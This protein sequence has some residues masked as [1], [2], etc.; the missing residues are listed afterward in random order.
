MMR[1]LPMCGLLLLLNISVG[2]QW[3]QEPLPSVTVSFQ[4]EDSIW[5]FAD[6][7]QPAD[8]DESTPVLLLL[9][10]SA[11]NS[12]EYLPMIP[13]FLEWGFSC[14]AVDARGGGQNYGRHNR[15]NANLPHHGGGP[16]AY[17]DFKAALNW[18]KKVNSGKITIIGSSYSAGRMFAVLLE[19]PE[20]VVAAAAFSPGR[21]FAMPMHGASQSWS[22]QVDLPVFV[23][24][25][26]EEM[27]EETNQRFETIKS[28][29]K[30]LFMQEHGVHAASTLRPDRNPEGYRYNMEGL[31]QF[32]MQYSR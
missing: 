32:L 13:S 27:T 22:E 8:S 17:Y 26:P 10:Q 30:V 14:L 20:N 29:T 19:K 1:Y 7:Y 24:W 4:T 16:Q 21:G 2:A 23:T 9:H 31:K 18:L 25:S 11:S 5:V 6:Y 28:D 15:T 3:L 12:N